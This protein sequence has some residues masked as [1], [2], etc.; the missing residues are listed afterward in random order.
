[1]PCSPYVMLSHSANAPQRAWSPSTERSRWLNSRRGRRRAEVA[2]ARAR[3][4]GHECASPPPVRVRV[5]GERQVPHVFGRVERGCRRRRRR[6]RRTA[7]S[8]RTPLRGLDQRTLPASVPTSARTPIA[9]RGDLAR[10][11]LPSWRAPSP[12]RSARDDARAGGMEPFDERPTDATRRAG[13]TTCRASRSIVAPRS[14]RRRLCRRRRWYASQAP[15]PSLHGNVP[16][17]LRKP[18]VRSDQPGNGAADPRRHDGPTRRK[19][20]SMT[21]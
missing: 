17:E 13:H 16:H 18:G 6:S 9:E 1:M 12:S 10:A 11:Q 5:D 3:A 4:P 15:E 8:A 2:L 20:S 14:R 7:R 21:H 19:A